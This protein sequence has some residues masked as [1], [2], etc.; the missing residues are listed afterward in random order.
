CWE[1]WIANGIHREN[2]GED[3]TKAV[4]ELQKTNQKE[5][6]KPA[7]VKA[8]WLY[9]VILPTKKYASLIIEVASE[10]QANHLIRE[11]IRVG[12]EVKDCQYFEK[13]TRILQCYKC[14][15]YGHTQYSCKH[16]TVCG[17]CAGSHRTD[18]C[19]EQTKNRCHN[20]S[21]DGH[22]TRSNICPIRKKE[23]AKAEAARLTAPYLYP[24]AQS[25]GSAR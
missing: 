8:R 12:H 24:E 23:K 21:K 4:E 17:N 2:L 14:Q 10:A 13:A 19:T 6:L 9:K 20:C 3:I 11:G 7:I 5:G 18:A 1:H 16:A 22:N 25:T 15:R